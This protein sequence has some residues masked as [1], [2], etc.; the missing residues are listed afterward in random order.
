MADVASAGW[1]EGDDGDPAVTAS[2]LA[3]VL[4]VKPTLQELVDRL[5]V[6]EAETVAF[7]R[8]LPQSVVAH[9]AR[10]RRMGQTAVGL[11]DHTR[12]H[13]E[14]IKATIAAIRAA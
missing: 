5:L 11:P 7:M 14:Q 1:V 8:A 10:F 3:A 12:E 4:A 2:R 9:R 13:I 6:D